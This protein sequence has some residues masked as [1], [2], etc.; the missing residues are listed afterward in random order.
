M[1][2]QTHVQRR[3][4]WIEYNDEERPAAYNKR[5]K[6]DTQ[7]YRKSRETKGRTGREKEPAN[8]HIAKGTNGHEREYVN[9][10]MVNVMS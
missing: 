8:W 1:Y 5:G 4:E 3:N 9:M 7:E 2:I 6:R 10:L